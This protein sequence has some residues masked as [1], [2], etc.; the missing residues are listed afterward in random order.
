VY[1]DA[2]VET[3]LIKQAGK[4]LFLFYFLNIH[5]PFFFFNPKWRPI[6]IG[7]RFSIYPEPLNT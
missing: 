5:S 4:T 7:S 6:L 3:R 2:D 1:R